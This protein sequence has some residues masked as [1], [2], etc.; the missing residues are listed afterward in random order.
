MRFDEDNAITIQK[1]RDIFIYFLLDN[2][3]VVYVGKTTKGI[4]RPLSHKNKEFD[5]IKI[6]YCEEEHLDILENEYILKYKPIY[7][8]ICNYTQRYSLSKIKDII[9][10]RYNF[11]NFF[12]ND[13]K[14]I[15]KRLGIIPY[16]FKGIET[17]SIE[18]FNKICEVVENGYTK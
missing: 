1:Y 12:V 10:E 6:I 7:N 17:V 11:T 3:E 4:S 18:E 16:E 5:T 13:I 8:Q 9:R 15:N 2:G 14:K